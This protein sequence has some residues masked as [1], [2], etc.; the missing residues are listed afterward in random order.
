M[1]NEMTRFTT[2]ARRVLSRAQEAAETRQHQQIDTA[3]LLIGFMREEHSVAGRVLHDLGLD[4]RRVE[5]QVSDLAISPTAPDWRQFDLSPGA[6][7]LL[8]L[9]VDEARNMGN[10]YIGTEHLILGLTRLQEDAALD[11]LR[12]LGI[13]PDEIRRQTMK[14]IGESGARFM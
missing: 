3:H 11:V 8:E 6:K 9:A 7:K 1:P 13:S 12:Q 5:A 4:L 14:I 2:R 10:P